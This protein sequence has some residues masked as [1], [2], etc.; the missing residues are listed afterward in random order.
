[1]VLPRE[2]YVEQ[3]YL[4][5]LLGERLGQGMPVQDLLVQMQHEL[6]ASTKLP[7]AISF[8][9]SELKH[10]GV[11]ASGL[12]RLSHYFSSW[13]AFL[14]EEAELDRGRFDL[15]I[16]L[17]ILYAEAD[18][19]SRSDNPQGVFFFQF[20][21]MCRNR[22]NY[23]RGLKAMSEDGVYSAAWSEWILIVRRQLGLVDLADLIYGR[24][25]A[26]LEYRERRL[27]ETQGGDGGG[28]SELPYQILFGEKE[29][30]IAYANRHKDPLYLFAA[31]QR[32]L[33][34][35]IVPKME[36]VDDAIDQIPQM[37][38]RLERLEAR[39]KLMEE[40]QKHQG[41]DLSK[42]YTRKEID[43]PIQ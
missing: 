18:Y 28:L 30:R 20:E 42:F 1:M 25:E 39:I 35:P 13:Q 32:H 36:K 41:I 4:F 23:D 15:P 14:I 21:A 38:R 2:E 6:L 5:R 33:G 43:P 34:Y 29:G 17:K 7:M 37:Q 9:A 8:L 26:F 10:N 3:A 11:M 31:M 16:A 19:R 24:S 27:R 12:K 22:L 40:E